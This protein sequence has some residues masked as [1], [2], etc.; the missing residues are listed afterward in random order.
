M[1]GMGGGVQIDP[2][3]REYICSFIPITSL[4]LS[5]SLQHVRWW[6]GRRPTRRRRRFLLCLRRRWRRWFSLRRRHGW[7]GR[8]HQRRTERRPR[9]PAPAFS[10]GRLPLLKHLLLIIIDTTAA[11]HA[12]PPHP[13]PSP[14]I[15][16]VCG[17]T[18]PSPSDSSLGVFGPFDIGLWVLFFSSS[19]SFF[20]SPHCMR[21]SITHR[22]SVS[23]SVAF[24]YGVTRAGY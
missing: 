13:S 14:K 8:W 9:P 11:T 2:E 15:P 7:H 16:H 4:T 1:G 3:M 22:R 21:T 18:C 23:Q 24:L 20:C 10:T 5:C 17:A 12:S 19:S 6:Y